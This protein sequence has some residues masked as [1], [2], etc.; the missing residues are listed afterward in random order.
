MELDKLNCIDI[1]SN[2]IRSLSAVIDKEY[3]LEFTAYCEC[4]AR[5]IKKGKIIDFEALCYSV[6]NLIEQLEKKS[7]HEIKKVF[8]SI[9]GGNIYSSNSQGRVKV[10]SPFK[11]ISAEDVSRAINSAK[12]APLPNGK[13]IIHVIPREFVIDGN[14]GI[15]DPHG[16]AGENLEVNVHIISIDSMFLQNYR[17][18]FERANVEVKDF[19]F[20][21][22]ASGESI[23]TEDEKSF[24]TLQV[25]IGSGTTEI[26]VYKNG[27][28]VFSSVLPIGGDAITSDIA[29]VWKIPSE[30]AEKAKISYGMASSELLEKN[31][32]I[33]ISVTDDLHEKFETKEL[34]DIIEARLEEI[35]GMIY[36]SIKSLPETKELTMA[37]VTGGTSR[38]P[39]ITLLL[40]RFLESLGVKVSVKL[41]VPNLSGPIHFKKIEDKYKNPLYSTIIGLVITGLYNK[42]GS[43]DIIGSP[44]ITKIVDY[45]RSILNKRG[46]KKSGL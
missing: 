16:M 37:V 41:G 46:G 14:G 36:E 13:E 10:A 1:G 23:L 29:Q 8:A 38:M 15:R 2:K 45:F 34:C 30:D 43:D 20:Q 19:V 21:G 24:G 22:F 44:L 25:N 26:V 39:G 3:N 27:G 12:S 6:E 11:E 5:G 35:F 28:P 17:K 31:E 7:G 33:E 9:S 32:T 40:K 4:E 42:I 18:I